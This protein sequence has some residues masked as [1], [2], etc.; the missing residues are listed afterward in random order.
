MKDSQ[1]KCRQ[2]TCFIR[3]TKKAREKL[4]KMAKKQDTTIQDLVDELSTV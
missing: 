3:I 1:Y 2:E 4:R